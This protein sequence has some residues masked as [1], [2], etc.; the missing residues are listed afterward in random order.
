MLCQLSPHTPRACR[1]R[2]VTLTEL[3]IVIAGMM[4]LAAVVVPIG[5]R[6]Y[7]RLHLRT[8]SMQVTD[9]LERG[10]WYARLG[11]NST[12]TGVR[13]FPQHYV[14]FAGASYASRTPLFD[15]TVTFALGV[16]ATGTEEVVFASVTGVPSTTGT[17][18]LSAGLA[19]TSITIEQF[20]C[21]GNE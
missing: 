19:T 5:V 15:E 17:I 10:F 14:L 3:T 7:A 12:S 9:T 4:I 20:G 11:R 18:T 16:S 13:V 21:D 2:G 1:T 8:A 6:A